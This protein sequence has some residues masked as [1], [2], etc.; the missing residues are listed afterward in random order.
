VRRFK[1]I[2]ELEQ[3]RLRKMVRKRV[4][5][6]STPARLSAPTVHGVVLLPKEHQ[7]T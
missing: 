5:K 4:E 7:S 3:P 6:L 2:D 1:A